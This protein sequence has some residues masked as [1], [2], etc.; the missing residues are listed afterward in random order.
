MFNLSE[1]LGTTSSMA[2]SNT[3]HPGNSRGIGP[4][5]QRV[6][7]SIAWDMGSDVLR[8]FWPEIVHK[9]KL[10]F[11]ERDHQLVHIEHAAPKTGR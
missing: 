9:L 4:A 7:L 11:R 10:P 8:E 1:W 2:L 5:S 6:G 3:Y